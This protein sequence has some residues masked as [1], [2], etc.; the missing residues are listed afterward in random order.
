MSDLVCVGSV[1]IDDIVY[2]DGRTQ[3]GVLGGGAIHAAAGM[4]VWGERPG[5]AVRIGTGLPAHIAPFLTRHFDLEGLSPLAYPQVRAWQVFEYDGTRREL[6]R[7]DMVQP[8][9]DGPAPH[10][11]PT[12]WQEARGLY[13]LLDGA[14]FMRWRNHHR[15]LLTLWEPNQPYM[16]HKHA[17]EFKRLMART[18]IVSPNTKEA[19]AMFG[20][21]NPESLVSEML[22]HG[23]EV[24]A[25]RMGAEGSLVA[26][27]SAPNP[28][29][30]PA[31]PVETLVDV[32]G[33][34]N[35]YC[36]AFLA[37][38]VRTGSALQAGR[39]GAVAASFCLEGHG[40][41]DLARPDLLSERDRRRY[42]I[43]RETS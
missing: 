26:T 39:W 36:G 15:A 25:L 5:L 21:L 8:F 30:I 6:I 28:L 33:A 23:A 40:V 16:V 31:V 22:A 17:G 41:I 34:G 38:W 35:T 3:M 24:V 4:A 42:W 20:F 32:T 19:R 2:P 10:E 18:G 1:F 37:G 7:T 43:E 14:N 12:A 29:Y 27:K 11:L 9:Q 13:L